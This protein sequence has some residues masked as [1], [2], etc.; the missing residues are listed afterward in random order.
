[1]AIA[2]PFP[3][4][5]GG[6]AQ[7]SSMLLD[8]LKETYADHSFMP[9]SFSRLYPSILFPGKT[10]YT[11]ETSTIKS[12]VPAILNSTN[13][14]AWKKS[15]TFFA[16]NE[17]D[18][19]VLQWWHPFFAPVLHYS[20][21]P[22]TLKIAICHNVSPHE[23]FPWGK[24]LTQSFLRN[25]DYAVVHGNSSFTEASSFI[26]PGKLIK[27]FHPVY[28]QYLNDDITF[29]SAR[30]KLGYSTNDKILLFFGLIRPYK[31]VIDLLDAVTTLP[32]D[33]KLLIVGEAYSGSDEIRAKIS[34][35]GLSGRVQWIS[36]FVPD[37]DVALYFNCADAVVLPYRTATQSG[38]AQIALSFRKPLVLTD[39]GDLKELIDTGSTGFLSK[40]SSPTDLSG[41][42]LRCLELSED[43][44]L[45]NRIAQKAGEFSWDLYSNTLMEKIL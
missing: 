37:K 44:G 41:A 33:I 21:P 16:E 23:G 29:T 3:P 30:E 36:R 15:R 40:P 17:I 28:N 19:V 45:A 12:E 7:F 43:P 38:V 27:L 32:P 2:G 25:M 39:T 1:M 24:T 31:G 18:A 11:E 22:N 8:S 14:F 4:Y 34:Q 5:R 10:Q 26:P 13:P 6:I 42:I 20:I 35:A 9:I